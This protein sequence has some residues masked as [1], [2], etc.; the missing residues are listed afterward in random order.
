MVIL[1][2]NSQHVEPDDASVSQRLLQ[3][4]VGGGRGG[5]DGARGNVPG[6]AVEVGHHS[7]RL[8]DEQSPWGRVCMYVCMYVKKPQLKPRGQ[9]RV[10]SGRPSVSC[11]HVVPGVGQRVGPGT[12]NTE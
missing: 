2:V 10:A 9:S 4:G 3:L 12:Q 5:D 8:A 6:V 7:A 11:R 1:A